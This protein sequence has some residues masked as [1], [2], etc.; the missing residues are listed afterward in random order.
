MLATMLIQV[1]VGSRLQGISGKDTVNVRLM[2][3]ANT[4]RLHKFGAR[5]ADD[6]FR[7]AIT[8][9]GA[10]ISI[11]LP[12]SS[13]ITDL[14]PI[15]PPGWQP[16][17]P[18][19]DSGFDISY[20]PKAS[21]LPTSIKGSLPTT[22]DTLAEAL[23]GDIEYAVAERSETYVF[24]HAGVVAINGAALIFPGESHS[25]KSTLVAALVDRGATYYSDEYAVVTNEGLVMPFPRHLSLRTDLIHPKG[26]TDLTA[27]APERDRAERGISAGQIMFLMFGQDNVWDSEPLDRGTAYVQLCKNTVGF[28][29]RP[30]MSFSYL[31]RL[32]E[33][34]CCFQGI[35]GDATEAA[36]LILKPICER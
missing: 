29:H 20:K 8:C 10:H 1:K 2:T 4:Q 23:A 14:V 36:Q 28:R 18:A 17:R 9:L 35:R 33:S 21:L 11:T 12:D 34:A 25:G 5:V 32:I 16:A 22:R 6:E 27:H 24:V 13:W 31:H 7:I 26:R 30:E 19:G 15:L 3:V